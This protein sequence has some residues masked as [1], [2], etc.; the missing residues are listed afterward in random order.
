MIAIAQ[1]G[2]TYHY[3]HWIPSESGP[4]ITQFGNIKKDIKGIS[5][6]KK[7]QCEILEEIMFRLDIDEPIFS[8]SLDNNNLIFSSNYMD[9]DNPNLSNWYK[10][11]IQDNNLDEMMDYYHYPF[12]E[13]SKRKLSIAIPKLFRKSFYENMKIL[14]AR[15][16]NLSSGIFSAENGAR[17]WFHA[18]QL[19]SYVVWKLGNRK[20]DEILYVSNNQLNNYFSITRLK[21][22]VKINWKYGDNQNIEKLCKYIEQLINGRNSSIIPVDKIFLYTCNGKVQDVKYFEKRDKIV[23][24]NPFKVLKMTEEKKINFYDTLPFAETGNAFEKIDV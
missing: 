17:N 6:Y 16:N 4:M 24:L 9:D 22:K 15:L 18:D 12:H 11:Q 13:H 7:Y 3:L 1:V 5:D 19:D 14:K 21:N 23:L 10:M 8:F 20:Q 2:I